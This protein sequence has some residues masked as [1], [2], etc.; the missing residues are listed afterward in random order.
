MIQRV[1]ER[2]VDQS[3]PQSVINDPRVD[4]NPFSNEV[5]RS[6]VND[7]GAPASADFRPPTRRSLTRAMQ[8][9]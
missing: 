4:W 5:K 1:L 9:C 7:L 6:P 3:I 8:N 2:I